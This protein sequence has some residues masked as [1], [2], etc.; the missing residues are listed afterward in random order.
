MP[1]TGRIY[2]DISKRNIFAGAIPP[3]PK[4]PTPPPVKPIVKEE[5]K[6]QSPGPI[7]AFIRLTHIIPSD[8]E[9]YFLN[10][11]YE[12][13]EKKISSKNN[14][15]HDTFLIASKDRT[16]TFFLAKVLHIEHRDVFFQVRD[17]AYRWHLGDTLQ[18]AYGEDGANFLSLDTL[19]TLDVELDYA[20]AKKETE[21]DKEVKKTT[22]QPQK[23]KGGKGN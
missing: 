3:E 8:K 14:S 21:K 9:A 10:L 16:Y 15:G 11:F 12:K 23:K 18:Q 20:W 13:D 4:K 7:P 6:P 1:V 2:A 19:D 5:P 22:K 17:K